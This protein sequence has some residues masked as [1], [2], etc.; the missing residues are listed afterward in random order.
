MPEQLNPFSWCL[1]RF[2]SWYGVAFSAGPLLSWY[3]VVF[4]VGPLLS[5]PG[6]VFSVGP[7]L[8]WPPSQLVC[9]FRRYSRRTVLTGDSDECPD[10]AAAVVQRLQ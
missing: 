8:S 3:G 7:L 2:L 5:W 6:V 9:V 10:D 1:H 4:S